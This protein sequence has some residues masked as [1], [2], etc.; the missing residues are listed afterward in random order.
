VLAG[1]YT[2][3]ATVAL[4]QR[5][6]YPVLELDIAYS[7]DDVREQIRAAAGAL[8]VAAAGEHMIATLNQRIAAVPS[9]PAAQRPL[10]AVYGPNGFTPGPRT[11][12]GALITL[13]GFENL[14][15]RAGIEYWG[16]L[17]LEDLLLARPQVLIV[18]AERPGAHAL[19]TQILAHPAL[20]KLRREITVAEVPRP[21]WSCPGPW[22]A[23]ALDQLAAARALVGP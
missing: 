12:S 5:L 16:S 7:L 15:A 2:A 3:R 22:I 23:D 1:R 9:R 18:E 6:G 4:L 21:L 14:A 17:S 10:A 13:A 11:L 8:G 20:A 19:A